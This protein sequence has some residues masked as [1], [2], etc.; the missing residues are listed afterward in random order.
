[1]LA[2]RTLIVGAGAFQHLWENRSQPA[3][4][5]GTSGGDPALPVPDELAQSIPREIIARFSRELLI[6]PPLRRAD[7]EDMLAS[8]ASKV[9]PYLR[10]TFL[11]MG[12]EQIPDA[13]VVQQGCRFIEDLMLQTIL[14]ERA[15]VQ[16]SPP[17]LPAQPE[18]LERQKEEK[19]AE[20]NDLSF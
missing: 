5:F 17:M 18:K 12:H 10:E 2:N 7:Y 15:S 4:G 3:I 6:L 19:F 13:M 1:M 11:R 20:Q 9:P 8:T 16:M 14:S